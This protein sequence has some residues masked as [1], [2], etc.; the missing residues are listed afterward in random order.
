MILKSEMIV[1]AKNGQTQREYK[2]AMKKGDLHLSIWLHYQSQDYEQIL[3][4][5]QIELPSNWPERLR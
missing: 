4:L 3:Y 2:T 1:F 5:L